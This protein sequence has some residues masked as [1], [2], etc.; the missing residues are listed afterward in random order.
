V[1][2]V[3]K[4]EKHTCSVKVLKDLK[5][6]VKHYASGMDGQDGYDS[7]NDDDTDD[8]CDCLPLCEACRRKKWVPPGIESVRNYWNNFTGAWKRIHP[9]DLI[10]ETVKESVTRVC[11]MLPFTLACYELIREVH[12]LQVLIKV[13]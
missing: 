9:C 1:A 13:C 5:D 12:L 6:F 7:N 8:E 2:R 11:Q 4:N 10:P 3:L